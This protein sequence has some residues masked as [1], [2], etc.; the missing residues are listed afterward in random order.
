MKVLKNDK[1]QV[2]S[3]WKILIA[4]MSFSTVV[5]IIGAVIGIAY[6]VQKIVS[7]DMNSLE[8]PEELIK[9][10][11]EMDMSNPIVFLL[12]ILQNV[13]II[14]V[15]WVYWKLLDK[16]PIRDLGLI[17]I[18]KGYKDLIMGLIFGAI[19]M[20]IVFAVLVISGSSKLVTPLST[21]NV[22]ISLLSGFIMFIFVGF[23]EEIFS[24]GYCL[25]VLKQTDRM[26]VPL[27]VSSIIFSL[28]HIGNSN[29]SIIGLLN[30][31]LVGVLFAYMTIKSHNIWMAIGYHIT[32]NYFQGN[33]F[34]FEVSGTAAEGLYSTRPVVENIINGGK[35]GPE[36]GLIATVV[37]LLG[38]V[39]IK[40]INNRKSVQ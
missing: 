28:M 25:T 2:R 33:I 14:L 6:V 12:F 39:F 31:F 11:T 4:Y 32:W 17:N 13:A 36:G 19:S 15:V 27:V 26:W 7:G 29:V 3:G 23:G 40:I 35:F 22:S 37:I 24:R 18:K 38:F 34:G 30:I 8:N 21:P 20:T 9:I 10:M 1:G 16:R 5:G